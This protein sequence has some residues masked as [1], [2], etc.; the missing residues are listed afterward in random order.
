MAAARSTGP[1]TTLRRATEYDV[2]AIVDLYASMSR[3]SSRMRFFGSMPR[4]ALEDAAALGDEDDAVA[5]VALLDGHVVGEARYLRHGD[6]EYEL[7]LAVADGHQGRGTGR[8]LLDLLRREA[9]GHG[10]ETLLAVVRIDNVAML[11]TLRSVPCAVVGP[12]DDLVVTA[13]VSCVDAMPGWSAAGAGRRVLIEYNSFWEA[14]GTAAVREAGFDVRQCVG[15]GRGTRRPC[16]LVRSGRCRLAEEADAVA[17]LLP[18]DDP[19]CRKVLEHHAAHRPERLVARS[20]DEWRAAA[21]R[22][23]RP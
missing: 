12:V 21:P 15:P 17:C 2:P 7:G 14:P 6:G 19:G 13:E 8:R 9:A 5:V 1:E 4:A 10:I 3:H 23:V 20:L 22:L 18:D 11:R 16:P